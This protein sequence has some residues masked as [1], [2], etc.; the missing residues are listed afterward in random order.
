MHAPLRRIVIPA[1]RKIPAQRVLGIPMKRPAFD[2]ERRRTAPAIQEP[3]QIE[4]QRKCRRSE[5]PDEK[6]QNRR[7][8]RG[9]RSGHSSRSF[10]RTAVSISRRLHRRY[11]RIRFR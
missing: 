2:F 8:D 6:I 5:N 1:L 10:A 11:G 9:N 7:D 3:P 4:P